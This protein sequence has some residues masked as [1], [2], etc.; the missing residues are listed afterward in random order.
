MKLSSTSNS[1]TPKWAIKGF[2]S[3]EYLLTFF[4][5]PIY[6]TTVEERFRISGVKIIGRYIYESKN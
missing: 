6:T 3:P 4:P 1:I 2:I 5:K